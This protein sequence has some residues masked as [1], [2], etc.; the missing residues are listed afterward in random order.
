[1]PCPGPQRT[2]LMAMLVDP[3]IIPM[4]SSPV[5]MIVLL[6]FTL[7]DV[8]IWIPS[9]FG[10]SAGANTWSFLSLM[11]WELVMKM[12]TPLLLAEV[13]PLKTAFETLF[14]FMLCTIAREENIYWE[15]RK[16]KKR[17]DKG[18]KKK[19]KK[20]TETILQ[21]GV[22]YSHCCSGNRYISR[23]IHLGHRKCR[24]Q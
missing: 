19:K 7:L 17:K 16:I 20:K 24:C 12:W 11:F 15:K 1:M 22:E 10:L 9:V 18:K 2:L 4:Q 14:N 23:Q 8:L 21:K 5:P 13:K 6:T 3:L